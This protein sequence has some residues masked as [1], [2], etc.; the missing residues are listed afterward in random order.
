MMTHGARTCAWLVGLALVGGLQSQAQDERNQRLVLPLSQ[1][2]RSYLLRAGLV[3]GGITVRG[4]DGKEIIVETMRRASARREGQVP[5]RAAGLRRLNLDGG[6]LSVEERDGVVRIDASPQRSVNLVVQVPMN[7]SLKLSCINGGDITVERVNGEI[8]VDNVNGRVSLTN[9]SGA[10]VA[11][12]LNQDV[13]VTMDR[14]AQDKPMSFSSLN[15]DIDVTLPS[16]VKANVRMKTDHGDAFSDFD[17]RVA[18]TTQQSEDRASPGRYRVRTDQALVAAINGG[19][20]ELRFTT[21]NGRIY[22]R[23]KK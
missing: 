13:V 17:L 7:T 14:V 12:A 16:D 20:P 4:Y 18:A 5:E 10:V 23:R 15:G 3:N 21:L 6:G 1:P 8:S 11:H 2:E 9:V 22:L 19:G